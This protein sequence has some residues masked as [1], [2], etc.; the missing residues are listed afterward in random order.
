VESH[1]KGNKQR[2]YETKKPPRVVELS[3][4]AG[5]IFI[6]V[7]GIWNTAKSKNKNTR[8]TAELPQ[9]VLYR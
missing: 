4:G 2:P 9:F 5:C 7:G 3:L 8:C 6:G 1:K